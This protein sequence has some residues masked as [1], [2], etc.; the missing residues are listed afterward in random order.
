MLVDDRLEL[1]SSEVEKQAAGFC[2]VFISSFLK[3]VSV[4]TGVNISQS[5]SCAQRV[6]GRKRKIG[7]EHK[8][9][10][11]MLIGTAHMPYFG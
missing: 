5:A 1:W 4:S 8:R 11:R 10:H 9:I 2:K 7:F 3:G 6:K